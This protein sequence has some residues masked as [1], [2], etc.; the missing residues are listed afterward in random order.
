MSLDKI[1][2]LIDRLEMIDRNFDQTNTDYNF[3]HG[4]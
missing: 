4:C 2:S 1:H 3:D